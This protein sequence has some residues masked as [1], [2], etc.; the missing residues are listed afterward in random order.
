MA[1]LITPMGTLNFP[2]LFEAKPQI[3]GS[4][5]LKY[6]AVL[7]FDEAARATAAYKALEDEVKRLADE[8]MK[9]HKVKAERIDLPIRDGDEKAEKYASYAGCTYISCKS[10]A[11]P[12]LIG[13]DKEPLYDKDD[14]FSGQLARFNVSPY[15]WE[16][17]GK[18]GI[19]IGLNGVQILK[20]DCPRL[21]G[22][23][24]IDRMFDDAN[25]ARADLPF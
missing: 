15:A 19:S 21:D 24:S 10:D 12:G 8:I 4:D 6:S 13:P 11:R 23:P 22:K 1:N 17:S 18:H 20:L 7:T 3:P 2:N 16:F 5:K 14:V 9:K 25:P